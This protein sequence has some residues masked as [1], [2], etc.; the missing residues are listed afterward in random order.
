MNINSFK[1]FLGYPVDS[2]FEKAL[3]GVDPAIVSLFIQDGE[4]YLHEVRYQGAR[5]L[6]KQ[7]SQI[8][9]FEQL[10]LLETNIYSLLKKVV[11]DYPYHQK[12]LLIFPIN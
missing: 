12:Q 11:P 3:N 7:V 4:D 6:G 1:L 5:Y 10:E 9:D 2:G 8:A